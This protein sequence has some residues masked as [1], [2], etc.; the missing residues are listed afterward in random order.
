MPK[1]FSDNEREYI[2]K[3]LK[4]EA[5][6]CMITYGIKKTSVDE[7]V[8]RV[9]IP[10]GTFYLFYESKELLFFDLINDLHEEIQKK[11][12]NRIAAFT[13]KITV[14]QLTELLFDIY[15]EV[16]NTG[17][18]SVLLNGD[19]ELLIRR[20]PEDKVKE[21]LEHDNFSMEQ[22]FQFLPIKDHSKIDAFGGA[23]RGVFMTLLYKREIGEK[24]FDDALR[25]M[26]RGLI[27]QIMEEE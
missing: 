25:I 1:K 27:L 17:L 12:L 20:L 24:I 3:R 8:K 26:L 21:H 13:E 16:N 22:L 10:K 15:N 9:N 14:D 11:L 2:K 4:D 18:L 5:M 23:F 19:M 6:K 7:L